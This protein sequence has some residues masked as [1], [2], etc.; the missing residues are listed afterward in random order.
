MEKMQMSE[1]GLNRLFDSQ[2]QEDC[3]SSSSSSGKNVIINDEPMQQEEPQQKTIEQDSWLITP[4]PYLVSLQTSQKSLIENAPLENLL[5]E[6]PSMSVF[7]TQEEINDAEEATD[8]NSSFSLIENSKV[9]FTDCL[10][11]LLK[12]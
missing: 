12:Y 3:N 2:Q 10:S 9:S 7:I 6:H 4:L 11:F 8:E 1:Y 5:I